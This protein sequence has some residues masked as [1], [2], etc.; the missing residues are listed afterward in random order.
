MSGCRSALGLRQA[1]VLSHHDTHAEVC[2][3]DLA[4][5]QQLTKAKIHGGISKSTDRVC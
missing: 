1:A 2:H 5:S 3:R 4:M